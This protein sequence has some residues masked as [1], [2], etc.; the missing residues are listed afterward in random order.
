MWTVHAAFRFGD[1]A[2]G[3]VD[4]TPALGVVAIVMVFFL[5]LQ[6]S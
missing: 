3:E 4:L 2:T 5:V 1:Y 6:T